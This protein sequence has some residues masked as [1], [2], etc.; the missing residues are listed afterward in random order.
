[1]SDFDPKPSSHADHSVSV[2]TRFVAIA[3]PDSD[4]G[5]FLKINASN[6]GVL[7]TELALILR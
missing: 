6:H 4:L 7:G 5:G 2:L 1:L 3:V